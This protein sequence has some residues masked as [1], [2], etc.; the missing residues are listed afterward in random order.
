MRVVS[1]EERIKRCNVYQIEVRRSYWG[2]ERISNIQQDNRQ[3]LS[4]IN[5]VAL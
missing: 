3:K 2:R 5:N 4:R 1:I